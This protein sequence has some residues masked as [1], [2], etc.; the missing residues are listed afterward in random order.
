[1]LSNINC[2][3]FKK[4]KIILKY[5]IKGRKIFLKTQIYLP[6]IALTGFS[7]GPAFCNQW[8]NSRDNSWPF[9]VYHDP[10]WVA[11]RTTIVVSSKKREKLEKGYYAGVR[12]VEEL[13]V[14]LDDLEDSNKIEIR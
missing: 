12:F 9:E 8:S 2:R 13:Q 11:R 6:I 1:M 4:F 14:D 7:N 5:N 3:G 10:E